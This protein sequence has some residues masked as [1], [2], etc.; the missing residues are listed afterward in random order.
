MEKENTAQSYP[1]GN[2]DESR[3][4]MVRGHELYKGERNVLLI[5][6]EMRKVDGCDMEKLVHTIAAK[7]RSQIL[8]HRWPQTAEEVRHTVNILYIFVKRGYMEDTY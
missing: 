3:T 6:E 4:H 7:K 2:A 1:F 8:G 5:E